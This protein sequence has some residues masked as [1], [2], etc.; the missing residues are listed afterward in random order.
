M[1]RFYNMQQRMIL[2][3]KAKGKCVKC[4][5]KLDAHFHADHI[6][7]ASKGGRTVLNNGQALCANCNYRK[8]AN[9]N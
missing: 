7:P 4:S 5:N 6:L 1:A 2:F 3:A 8:A 9:D